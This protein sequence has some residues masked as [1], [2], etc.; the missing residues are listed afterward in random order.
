MQW[1]R[2][3]ALGAAMLLPFLL[4][5]SP[6][7]AASI[8]WRIEGVVRA[9]E[10]E[11][12]LLAEWGSLGVGAG[13]DM[14]LRFSFESTAPDVDP[15]GNRGDYRALF[16]SAE[17]SVAAW[18]ASFD[19]AEAAT[20]QIVIAQHPDL[21]VNIDFGS[22]RMLDSTAVFTRAGF[23]G[24]DLYATDPTLWATDAL[25][26]LAPELGQLMPFL[27]PPTDDFAYG[28]FVLIAGCNLDRCAQ[29]AVEIT[30]IE[31][32]PEPAAAMLL[33]VAA[34]SLAARRAATHPRSFPGGAAARRGS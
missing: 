1:I 25:P 29:A 22:I 11:A 30:S 5:A 28:S 27:L 14:S 3:G 16:T 23:V 12:T 34:L 15:A 6:G 13:A 17:V 26:L 9:T 4:L 32:V 2:P 18:S 10:G 19:P 24:W 21:G 8:T 7:S 20:N 31:V 33:A